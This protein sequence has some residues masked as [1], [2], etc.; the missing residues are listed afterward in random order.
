MFDNKVLANPQLILDLTHDERHVLRKVPNARE[1]VPYLLNLPEEGI[2]LFTYTWVNEA[3]EAGAVIAVFGPGVGPTPYVEK[4]ADRPVPASMNFDNWEIEGLH[5]QQDLKFN[6]AHVQWKSEK[7]EL[8]LNFEATHPPYAYGSDPRG[9]M[10]YIADDRIEQSGVAV[11]TLRIGDRVIKFNTTAHRDHSWGTRDWH[12]AQNWKWVQAQSGKDVAVHFWIMEALG[13]TELRGYV[14]KENRMSLV[15]H[16]DFEFVYEGALNAK[17]W[18]AKVTDADQ[19]VTT[20]GVE[21]VSRFVLNPDPA[22][23]LNEHAGR[24]LIDGNPGVAW[25]EM[26]W[27]ESYRNHIGTVGPY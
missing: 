17:H 13:K 8:D 6:K 23:C 3:G 14:F 5:M 26:M 1:S 12:A 20:L 27:P 21:V 24:A 10:S 19:R 4:L 11:G 7:I 25:I 16:V 18:S 22:C 9:C 15:T 2:G